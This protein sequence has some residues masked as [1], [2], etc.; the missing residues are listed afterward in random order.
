MTF[1][2]QDGVLHQH[3]QAAD[4]AGLARR[5][6]S[7]VQ[8]QGSDGSS[9]SDDMPGL[10]SY[11]E[12]DDDPGLVPFF[13]PGESE[14]GTALQRRVTESPTPQRQSQDNDW[15]AGWWAPTRAEMN[16]PDE[17]AT[18][19][20]A[21]S[22]SDTAEAMN[23]IDRLPEAVEMLYYERYLKTPDG[24]PPKDG[25]PR[26]DCRARQPRL[27]GIRPVEPN[28]LAETLR[29]LRRKT[30]FAPSDGPLQDSEV[31]ALLRRH[32]IAW[33]EL[34]HDLR[35][36]SYVSNLRALALKVEYI[37]ARVPIMPMKVVVLAHDAGTAMKWV[38]LATRLRQDYPA[39]SWIIG[40]LRRRL[41]A[42]I[43][44]NV[45]REEGAA[46][47]NVLIHGARSSDGRDALRRYSACAEPALSPTLEGILAGWHRQYGDKTATLAVASMRHTI[48]QWRAEQVEYRHAGDATRRRGEGSQQTRDRPQGGANDI[49]L[50]PANN[51]VVGS[52]YAHP[53]LPPGLRQ[54]N[55]LRASINV[56][57]PPGKTGEEDQPPER[58]T[59]LIDSGSEITIADEKYLTDIFVAEDATEVLGIEGSRT[60]A[61]IG[62]LRFEWDGGEVHI[63]CQV[64]NGPILQH[65][66]EAPTSVLLGWQ[67]IKEMRVDTNM[68]QDY[69]HEPGE[70]PPWLEPR[71][72]ENSNAAADGADRPHD[73]MIEGRSDGN[74]S[75]PDE[76]EWVQCDH[77]VVRVVGDVPIWDGRHECWDTECVAAAK[78][79]HHRHG[80]GELKATGGKR[81]H[82]EQYKSNKDDAIEAFKK[83]KPA[84][85]AAKADKRRKAKDPERQGLEC[86]VTEK[87]LVRYYRRVDAEEKNA[88]GKDQLLRGQGDL[89]PT[90]TDI[91]AKILE[92]LRNICRRRRG[93]FKHER[94]KVPRV[95]TEYQEV[96]LRIPL[97]SDLVGPENVQKLNA[98]LRYS[99][100]EH[101]ASKPA[102]AR[103]MTEFAKSGLA[104]GLLE[105]APDAKHVNR[106]V[107]AK[108]WGLDSEKMGDGYDLRFCLDL[109]SLN[110]IFKPALCTYPDPHSEMIKLTTQDVYFQADG[111]K[112]F[113]SIPLDPQ[114]RE[115]M[116]FHTPLGIL[117]FKRLPM[118]MLSSAVFA[119]NAYHRAMHRH[120]KSDTLQ[121]LANFQDDFAGGAAGPTKWVDLL[122]RWDDFLHMC[123]QAGIT[124]NL[125]KCKWGYNECT[126][127][128]WKIR[129]GGEI[130]PKKSSLGPL[131]A[132]VPPATL[133]E[134]RSVLGILVQLKDY[135]QGYAHIVQPLH[136][137]TKGSKKIK[138]KF[139]LTAAAKQAFHDIKLLMLDNRVLFAPNEEDH[140]IVESDASDAGYGGNLF[141]MRGDEKRVVMWVSKSWTDAQAKKPV[142]WRECFAMLYVLD[143]SSGWT[144]TSKHKVV[145]RTDHKPLTGRFLHKL[146]HNQSLSTF[147]W[148]RIAGRVNFE[149]QY[150]PGSIMETSFSDH[151]SRCPAVGPKRLASLGK[152]VMLGRL[153][154]Q[155]EALTITYRDG[156]T[157][158]VRDAPTIMVYASADTDGLARV[159][160]K[161]RSLANPIDKKKPRRETVLASKADFIIA[162]PT[163]E[164]ATH[165]CADLFRAGVPFAFLIDTDLYDEIERR[166]DRVMD[167]RVKDLK[168]RAFK[169]V[170]FG[171]NSVWVIHGTDAVERCVLLD[172]VEY[173]AKHTDIVRVQ[174]CAAASRIRANIMPPGTPEGT[175]QA[176]K[177][178]PLPDWPEAQRPLRA[179][180][181]KLRGGAVVE[182]QDDKLLLWQPNTG[183][184]TDV[185][186]IV[187]K[188]ERAKL[189]RVVHEEHN[190]CYLTTVLAI[191]RRKY[192]WKNMHQSVVKDYKCGMCA[193]STM[194]RH[195]ANKMFT[196]AAAGL[197]RCDYAWDLYGAGKTKKKHT[198]VLVIMDTACR[199]VSLYA[200][201]T[202]DATSIASCLLHGVI[203]LRGI[204]LTLRSDAAPEL[205]GGVVTALCKHLQIDT[206]STHGYNARANGI[207]E[208]FMAYLGKSFRVM[209][210]EA[211]AEW[212]E[213]LS[214]LAFAWNTTPRR[215]LGGITPFEASHGMP[216]RTQFHLRHSLT[217]RPPEGM[218]WEPDPSIFKRVNVAAKEFSAYARRSSDEQAR[219][220]AERMNMLGYKE[221]PFKLHDKVVIYIP[222]NP[223]KLGR[224]KVKHHCH[225][226]GVGQIIKV[227]KGGRSYVIAI[228]DRAYERGH[229]NVARWQDTRPLEPHE[230]LEPT[231]PPPSLH[232]RGMKF[233]T[234]NELIAVR[235]EVTSKT[236]FL[237]RTMENHITD[238]ALS[239][240]YL[241]TLTP[242]HELKT[243]LWRETWLRTG[244]GRTRSMACRARERSPSASSQVGCQRQTS[245]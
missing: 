83:R 177:I 211:Y 68:H 57:L 235:D 157:G 34:R 189:I 75:A 110:H 89:P 20:R 74:D 111:M 185:R 1:R 72:E 238:S 199:E 103:F 159:E 9:D 175:A 207:V 123:E 170:A 188:S 244:R 53:D 167:A 21:L 86:A 131:E 236:F 93:A 26:G 81:S 12:S 41:D 19:K 44:E 42:G 232:R 28:L 91:P 146:H 144:G 158:L 202:R 65:D 152:R 148:E 45:L 180:Y 217:R 100:S 80:M 178:L 76:P 151:L 143:K 63:W 239:V 240:R 60:F 108:K 82:P 14:S 194:R 115:F 219:A 25:R 149:I 203:H 84:A 121:N 98:E 37:V 172:G 166:V 214:G 78:K 119:Q 77:G 96:E 94:G 155:L 32:A 95:M 136:D 40:N 33:P 97:R 107:L 141:F 125:A 210:D 87:D 52:P 176:A 128:S 49:G 197:P 242:Q 174:E 54:R 62:K 7:W 165:D 204:P 234:K 241:T 132:M 213:Y 106:V 88:G 169:T 147:Y 186:I 208:R 212:N 104:S 69:R 129:S 160:Q 200:L 18:L 6:P 222:P 11:E 105:H 70:L 226:T 156:R 237:V 187:P 58:V 43:I 29:D 173:D 138:K 130:R 195:H 59:T 193:L 64:S 198:Q 140:L 35:Q 114:S 2:D 51:G 220:T 24:R 39:R 55:N 73:G 139:S 124:L 134:T 196:A 182:R 22:A 216:A 90:P 215:T 224:R 135:V 205:T 228:G 71:P 3:V 5:A 154:E 184:P 113:W 243:A 27:L 67:A 15:R 56:L 66:G 101:W 218:S 162:A 179:E 225:Y 112:Q 230:R 161:W 17:C 109:S 206:I 209:T 117:R 245:W 142:F 122:R 61:R 153:L 4:A 48:S 102:K 16:L 191:L 10:I 46:L 221:T 229:L 50:G 23:T 168:R 120:L 36:G 201:K 92:D 171:D 13:G 79:W 183:E 137:L 223:S 192:F 145:A 38:D 163:L 127:F 133:S 85:Y 116:G 99:R 126:F 31:R 118:G 233:D 30:D 231:L 47:H 8:E 181:E 150:I 190:H 227:L 164:T